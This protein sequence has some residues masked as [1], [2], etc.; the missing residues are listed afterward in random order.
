LQEQ[1]AKL[2]AQIPDKYLKKEPKLVGPGRGVDL[3]E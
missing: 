2:R 3:G 1:V